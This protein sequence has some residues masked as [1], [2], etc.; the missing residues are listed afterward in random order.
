MSILN[1][2]KMLTQEEVA[3]LLN[4]HKTQVSMLRQVGVLKSI[5]TGRN[6]MFSKEAIKQFQI[7]YAGCDVSN[8]DAAKASYLEVTSKNGNVA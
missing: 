8:I 3:D 7:D 4:I 2:L 5:K 6:F 1:E